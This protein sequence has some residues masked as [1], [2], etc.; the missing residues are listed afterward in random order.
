MIQS[1]NEPS[2]F[3]IV[4]FYCNGKHE[5]RQATHLVTDLFI[6]FSIFSY[7]NFTFFRDRA[8]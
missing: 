2:V 3:Q 5:L 1:V 6:M 4:R 8:C 7:E